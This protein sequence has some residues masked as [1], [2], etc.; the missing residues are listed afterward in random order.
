LVGKPGGRFN[1]GDLSVEWSIILK[2]IERKGVKMRVVI[3]D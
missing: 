3:P 2:V 1:L